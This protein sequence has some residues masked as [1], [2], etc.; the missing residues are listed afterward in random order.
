MADC[1]VVKKL[2][3]LHPIDAEGEAVLRN[4]GQ[5]EIVRVEIKRPRNVLFHRKLFALLTIILDNQEFYK[6]IEDLLDVAKI[7]AG[8]VRVVETKMGQ[9]LVPKSIS[10]ASMDDVAF[11]NFYDR[12]IVWVVTEVIPGLKR[13]DLDEAVE[14]EL[15][16][17]GGREPEPIMG[18]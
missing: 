16:E 7:R 8:H 1:L 13:K 10:F 9:V 5:G 12:V 14:A 15:L 11:A 18:E 17:F 6:S 2:K 4:L 3:A